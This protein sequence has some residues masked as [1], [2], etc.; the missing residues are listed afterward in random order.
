MRFST[1]RPG[2]TNEYFETKL[3]RRDYVGKIY[4]RTKFGADRLWNGASTWWWNITV[5]WLSSPTFF[6]F[7]SRFLGQP[8]GRNC[9]P[10]CTL[11]G[12]KV[13][14]RLIHVPSGGLVPS[15]SLWGVFGPKNRQIVTRKSLDLAN[16][17]QKIATLCGEGTIIVSIVSGRCAYC[18]PEPIHGKIN[19]HRS[20]YFVVAICYVQIG[21][22]SYNVLGMTDN[23]NYTKWI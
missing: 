11:N 21:E 10:N 12:S 19:W 17:L 7:F 16:F 4:K 5:L 2:K 9:G 23:C 20:S 6:S 1:S 3:G 18:C 8:T 14:L 15:N 22:L 13:V